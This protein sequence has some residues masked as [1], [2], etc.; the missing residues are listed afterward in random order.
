MSTKGPM[1]SKRTNGRMVRSQSNRTAALRSTALALMLVIL[2]SPANA[3]EEASMPTDYSVC[4]GCDIRSAE[5]AQ[6]KGFLET[7]AAARWQ[8][9]GN[10]A[11]WVKIQG[12]GGEIAT[13]RYAS[14]EGRL[15]EVELVGVEKVEKTAEPGD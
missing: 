5:D 14:A 1:A 6:V 13:W 4:N 11:G 10:S 8:M 7:I 2:S 9:Y 12:D 15:D 3:G